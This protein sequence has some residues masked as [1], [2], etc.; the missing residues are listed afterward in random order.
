MTD[1]RKNPRQADSAGEGRRERG[2]GE[3]KSDK[4]KR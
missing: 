2:E 3:H 4:K 1:R